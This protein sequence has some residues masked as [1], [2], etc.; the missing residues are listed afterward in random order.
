M[1]TWEAHD[2][3]FVAMRDSCVTTVARCGMA[4]KHIVLGRSILLCH[5]DRAEVPFHSLV[6]RSMKETTTFGA[7]RAYL[8]L[9]RT[10]AVQWYDAFPASTADRELPLKTI[11]ASGGRVGG[12]HSL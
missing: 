10:D 5:D 7:F 4:S 11:E 9:P 6:T 12:R 3:M 1:L 2:Q 8:L